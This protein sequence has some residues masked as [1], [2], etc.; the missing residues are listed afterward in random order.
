MALQPLTL[1]PRLRWIRQR[2]LEILSPIEEL[3]MLLSLR[4][5][6]FARSPHPSDAPHPLT[7]I[8]DF[9][10]MPVLDFLDKMGNDLDRPLKPFEG[11]RKVCRYDYAK[12]HSHVTILLLYMQLIQPSTPTSSQKLSASRILLSI[13]THIIFLHLQMCKTFQGSLMFITVF[14]F[15]P[16]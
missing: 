10:K 4:C 7:Y 3:E 9:S 13:K 1:R 2:L 16:S 6:S 12:A 14:L 11:K 8:N 5:V 15:E